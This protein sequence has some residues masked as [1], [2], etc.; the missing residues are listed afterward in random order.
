MVEGQGDTETEEG[1]SEDGQKV[2]SGMVGAPEAWQPD[3]T[4]LDGQGQISSMLLAGAPLRPSRPCHM[5]G[6][7]R[8]SCRPACF[9][10]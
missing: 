2:G 1:E 10:T 4:T 3:R 6:L 8:N 9:P 5:T 7:P